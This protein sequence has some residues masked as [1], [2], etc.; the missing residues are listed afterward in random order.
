MTLVANLPPI[1]CFVRREFLYNHS[2]HQ[3]EYTPCIWISIKSVRAQAFRIEAYLPEYGALYDKLPLHSFVSRRDN[4]E[5]D[6]FLPLDSLQIW[7]CFDYDFTVIRK[8]F[9]ANLTAEFLAKDNR[10]YRG[11]YLFTVDHYH[12]SDRIDT[13]YSEQAADHKSFNFIELDNGQ[14]AA[15]PNNRCRFLDAASNPDP[16]LF[17]DFRV[18]EQIYRVETNPKWSLGNST[19]V[20]YTD[21]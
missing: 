15:Q 17:P 4:L 9:L 6:Q 14:Y 10:F 8:D 18:C 12:N 11:R 3:G 2:Q 16:L 1:Q 20:M 5:V 13:G 21:K 19:Q 7:D